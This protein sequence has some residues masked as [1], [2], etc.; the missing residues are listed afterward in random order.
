[1]SVHELV[2]P[3]GLVHLE[4]LVPGFNERKRKLVFI[5]RFLK[6]RYKVFQ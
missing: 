3:L 4:E 5:S 1:M 2:K 6:T